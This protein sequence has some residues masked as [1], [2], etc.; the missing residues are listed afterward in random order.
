MGNIKMDIPTKLSPLKFD[1]QLQYVELND[2]QIALFIGDSDGYWN[3]MSVKQIW[4]K[5]GLN[6]I[7][8]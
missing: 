7:I 4:K 6:G 8:K 2:S 5:S 3:L 1:G